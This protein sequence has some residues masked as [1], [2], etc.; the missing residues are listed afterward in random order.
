MVSRSFV[1]RPKGRRSRSSSTS[2]HDWGARTWLRAFKVLHCSGPLLP[3]FHCKRSQG[4]G[5]LED[6]ARRQ[7]FRGR[8]KPGRWVGSRKGANPVVIMESE[9][10]SHDRLLRLTIARVQEG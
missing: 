1:Q 5:T 9:W 10:H 7:S 2:I 4:P 8:S 6:A 3:V